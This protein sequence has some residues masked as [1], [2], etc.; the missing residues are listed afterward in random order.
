MVP[1]ELASAVVALVELLH[2]RDVIFQLARKRHGDSFGAAS[3]RSRVQDLDV[4]VVGDRR[5]VIPETVESGK[6]GKGRTQ[7]F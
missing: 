6:R 1:L 4:D 7:L 2:F 5:I 3:P